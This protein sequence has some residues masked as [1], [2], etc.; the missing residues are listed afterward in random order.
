M[1]MDGESQE[2]E[3]HRPKEVIEGPGIPEKSLL[4]RAQ[5]RQVDKKGDDIEKPEQMNPGLAR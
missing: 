5:K 2:K 1:I 3:A 4:D